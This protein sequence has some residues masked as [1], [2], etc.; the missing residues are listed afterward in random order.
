MKKKLLSLAAILAAFSGAYAQVGINNDSPGASLEI[1]PKTTGSR[2]EGILIPRLTGNQIQTM[3]MQLGMGQNS[4]L[5]YATSAVTAPAG[6]TADLTSPGFYYYN[7]SLTKWVAINNG[8]IA[9]KTP[10][11]GLTDGIAA[12]TIDSKNFD[13]TWNW[14][15]ASTQTPLTL[16][17]NAL[18]TGTLLDIGTANSA[19][20]S[21]NGLIRIINNAAPSVSTGVFARLQPNNTASSGIS[22]LNN[23]N[24]GFGILLPLSKIHIAET[25]TTN[26]SAIFVSQASNATA[27]GSLVGTGSKGMYIDMGSASQDRA[28][29]INQNGTAAD[30]RGLNITMN[31]T[32]SSM[33]GF[34]NHTGTG[35][36]LRIQNNNTLNNSDGILILHDGNSIGNGI[37]IQMQGTA[38]TGDGINILESGASNAIYTTA[39]T[40]SVDPTTSVSTRRAGIWADRTIGSA[41]G[42]NQ[43]SGYSGPGSASSSLAHTSLYG[44]MGNATTSSTTDSYLFGVIGE[45]LSVGG[46]AAVDRS[47]GVLGNGQ[48]AGVFGILGYRTSASANAGVYGNAAMSTG[49]GR[50]ARDNKGA[51]GFGVMGIGDLM[52]AAFKGDV[53]GMNISGNRYGMYIDGATYTNNIIANVSTAENH[54]DRIT[55]Y[56]PTSTTADI[57]TRGIAEISKGGLIN[58]EFDKNFSTLVADNSIVVT[59]T[60][61]GRNSQIYLEREPT[62]SGFS[63][64]VDD[65]GYVKFSY[66][67]VGTRKGFENFS[68][69]KEILANDYDK[70]MAEVLHNEA[71]ISAEGKPVHWDG[72]ELKFEK[73]GDLRTNKKSDGVKKSIE[74][75]Q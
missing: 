43:G 32:N 24:S 55:T 66:I 21:T 60:P 70:N 31:S 7:H 41:A 40:G 49:A 46:S 61:I 58:V 23:G 35:E 47:G 18:T 51:K 16:R 29:V 13:Q 3:D 69:P 27:T 57:Y 10:I 26:Q 36:G 4:M 75:T 54:T 56:V 71:D 20:N 74:K 50:L 65:T 62:A 37:K 5:I 68:A 33:G 38:N 28:L 44:S 72:N 73:S 67:A 30:S 39:S 22:L 17:A 15:T 12:N 34:I 19:L 59:L 48:S 9:A 11:S 42:N 14:T 53:Y 2:P 52:G 63:A 64:K 45:V 1:T 8:G 25:G 6:I